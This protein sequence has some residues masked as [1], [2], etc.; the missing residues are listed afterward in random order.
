MRKVK[1]SNSN[2]NSDLQLTPPTMN[3]TTQAIIERLPNKP[4]LIPAEIAAAFG[5][6]TTNPILDAIKRGRINA[7]S[8]GGKFYIAREEAAR[9]IE[10]TAFIPDEA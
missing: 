9:Y 2:S 3:A 4:I 10:A 1:P 7:S 8:V 6:A 5:M